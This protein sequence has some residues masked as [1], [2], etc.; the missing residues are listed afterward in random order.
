MGNYIEIHSGKNK[1]LV[2][3]IDGI[4]VLLHKRHENSIESTSMYAS[5]INKTGI[6]TI[7][8]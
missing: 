2:R 5:H 6:M 3:M 4:G 7:M 8:L 1:S